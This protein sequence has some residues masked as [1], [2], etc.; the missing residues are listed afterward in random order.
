M[1]IQEAPVAQTDPAATAREWLITLERGL[2]TG[3]SNELASLFSDGAWWRDLLSLTWDFQN[4][5]GASAV[6]AALAEAAATRPREFA[7]GGAMPPSVSETGALTAVFTFES[8]HGRGR[9]LLRLIEDDSS[10]TW[11]GLSLLTQLEA[12]PG[13]HEQVDGSRPLGTVH[14][15]VPGRQLWHEARAATAEFGAGDPTVVI[16]G[17]GQSGLGAAARLQQLGVSTLIV[18]RNARVG[19]NWR[20]RY[21]SLTLHD[22]VGMDHMPYLPFPATWPTFTPK[23]KFANWL[24][25][26]AA[27]MELNTW[28]ETSVLSCAYDDEKAEWSVSVRRPDGSERTLH[29][30]HLVIATGLNGRPNMPEVP[31]AERFAG[32]IVHSSAFEGAKGWEGRKAVVVGAGVSGHDVAQAL[33]EGGAEVTM[34]QRSTTYVVRSD[35]WYS[36][37]LPFYLQGGPAVEDAD[38]IAASVPFGMAGSFAVEPTRIAAEMDRD[39]YER[40]KR[41]G[42][43]LDFGP[44]GQG[45]MAKHLTGVEGYYIDVGASDLI[46]D[47]KIAIKQGAGVREFVPE[48]VVLDDGTLLEADLVVF[49]TGY[50]GIADTAR[51]FLGDE[52]VN[53]VGQIYGVGPDGEMNAVWRRCA[54]PGLWFMV[55]QL[56]ATRVYSKFLA[57][58]IKAIEE[59]LLSW[60]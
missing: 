20:H 55:G 52:I 23:E 54:Q 9:G 46:A 48:G 12:L 28:T 8:D 26:Y 44:N 15:G 24:E 10:G 37:F 41:A 33:W 53:R 22:P 21:P 57:L 19:D 29:P 43:A 58:Q 18:E 45:L 4:F 49:A 25:F 2:A 1:T 42:F 40:L 51:Q 34:V 38:L 27:A 36:V 3:D 13:V 60:G 35:T 59:G 30:R 5:Q 6:G 11:L 47:G 50:H 14:G 7:I 31:G 56:Q 16:I 32:K 39:L 17:A